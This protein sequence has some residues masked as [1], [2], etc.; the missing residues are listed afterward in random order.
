VALNKWT[1]VCPIDGLSFGILDPV[2]RGDIVGDVDKHMHLDIDLTATCAGGHTWH[3]E[4]GLVL[5]RVS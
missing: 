1:T 3:L 4:G 5:E 2:L